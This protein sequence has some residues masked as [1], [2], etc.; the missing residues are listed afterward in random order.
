MMGAN[1]GM[2]DNNIHIGIYSIPEAARLT[3]LGESR[4]RR[5]LTGYSYAATGGRRK[6]QPVWSGQLAPIRGRR[7]VSFRD[8]IEMKFV[9]AFLRAGV[10]WKTIRDVQE[11]A[12]QQFHFDHPFST[13]RFRNDGSHLVMTVLQGDQEAGLFDIAT[14]Q[15]TF[16]AAADPF[17]EELEMNEFDEVCRWWPMGRQ[18][19][20]VLD[21]IRMGGRPIAARS[22]VPVTVIQHAVRRGLTAEHIASDYDIAA[23]EV[24]DAVAYGR[25]KEDAS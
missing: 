11:L 22:G 23:E 20:V 1:G 14:R 17:R 8:L 10:S 2:N 19:Y 13:N 5:W 6:V 3:G 25:S 4:V 12:R 7:A 16:L 15:Q 21:P 18:R 9:D 24:T